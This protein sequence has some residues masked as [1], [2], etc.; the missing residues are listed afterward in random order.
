MPQT[1][2]TSIENARQ[3]LKQLNLPDMPEE[4]L[5]LR[6]ELTLTNPDPTKLAAILSRNPI[7]LGDFLCL[8]NKLLKREADQILLD[9][10]AAVNLLGIK[11]IESIYMTTYFSTYLPTSKSH[12]KL[13]IHSKR[14]AMAATELS[15]W[16]NGVGQSEAYLITF[17]QNLGALYMSSKKAHYLEKFIYPQQ[18]H[19][20]R[21]F[22]E[23]EAHFHTTH[24]HLG[25]L[26]AHHWKLGSLLS[27]CILLHHQSSLTRLRDYDKQ[28]AQRVALIHIANGL[29][30]KQFEEECGQEE[31]SEL[32]DSIDKARQFLDLP[33][34]A[35]KA[36]I[37]VLQKWGNDCCTHS[38]SH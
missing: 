7:L 27:K 23:E 6:E 5:M 31:M 24:A 36:A 15:Y 17:M 38:A 30:Y 2:K 20:F 12:Q 10:Q 9:A 25:S 26:I 29:V 16:V 34:N 35:I 33:E 13:I 11:E 37:S 8:S 3:L 4:I 22:I 18:L 1:M 19:P 32:Q 14:A 21:D 28:I